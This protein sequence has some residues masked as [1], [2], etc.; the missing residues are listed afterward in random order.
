MERVVQYTQ[1]E[2]G[3]RRPWATRLTGS[4][5]ARD[6]VHM[7]QSLVQEGVE[8]VGKRTPSDPM[9]TG[10]GGKNP[11]DCR[12]SVRGRLSK[13]TGKY[14]WGGDGKCPQ[15]DSIGC[16]GDVLPWQESIGL[17]RVSNNNYCMKITLRWTFYL[18]HSFH[19]IAAIGLIQSYMYFITQA[20]QPSRFLA[21][22]CVT[23][24]KENVPFIK[25]PNFTSKG[26]GWLRWF[27]DIAS[28]HRAGRLANKFLL[29]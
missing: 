8:N 28:A 1:T 12:M 19:I 3:G 16:N 24:W 17:P 18:N 20:I 27:S 22:N 4:Q 9:E 6:L 2:S 10:C 29:G 13:D 25:Y 21:S 14:S 5:F 7:Q 11:S 26:W 23:E 15:T